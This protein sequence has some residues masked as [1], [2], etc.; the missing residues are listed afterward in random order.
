MKE[1]AP[2]KPMPPARQPF[3]VEF[4]GLGM[5]LS[6]GTP[7]AMDDAYP[8]FSG[9]PSPREATFATEVNDP[10]RVT[11]SHSAHHFQFQTETLVEAGARLDVM[12]LL[13]L[14]HVSVVAALMAYAAVSPRDL[15][16]TEYNLQFY[17]NLRQLSLLLV[18]PAIYIA[19]VFDAKESDFNSF[20]HAFFCTFSVGYLLTFAIE[21]LAT[22]GLRLAL[23]SIFEPEVFALTPSVALPILP[24][25]LKDQ[26]YRPKRITLLAVDFLTSCVLCP[27]VEESMKLALLVGTS[28]LPK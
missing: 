20:T 15:P 24:W 17:E 25:V 26:N 10:I 28:R 8:Y 21:I 12:A 19:S 1:Q 23:F 6:A 16:L 3:A 4:P 2:A 27:I 7:M 18:A 14:G 5:P 22:T 13:K 11:M 9:R